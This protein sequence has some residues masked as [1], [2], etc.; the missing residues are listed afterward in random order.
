VLKRLILRSLA[1]G[2]AGV[3][4]LG[5]YAIIA[6]YHSVGTIERDSLRITEAEAAASRCEAWETP[7]D[8]GKF[9]R[10]NGRRVVANPAHRHN[11]WSTKPWLRA[12]VIM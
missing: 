7:N 2:V 3:L 8:A 5:V 4:L 11:R 9:D 12:A 10:E 1:V 6:Q